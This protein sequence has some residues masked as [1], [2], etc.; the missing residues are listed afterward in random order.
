MKKVWLFSEIRE[1]A[2]DT[3]YVNVCCVHLDFHRHTRYNATNT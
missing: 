1:R 2:A 3:A